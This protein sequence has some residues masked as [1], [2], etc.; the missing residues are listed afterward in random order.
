MRVVKEAEERK[1]EIDAIKKRAEEAEKARNE[2]AEEYKKLK[3]QQ[4]ENSFSELRKTVEG[5][6]NAE[7]ALSRVETQYKKEKDVLIRRAEL[8]ED[9]AGVGIS[10]ETASHDIMLFMN[11]AIEHLDGLVYA[12]DHQNKPSL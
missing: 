3:K 8:A 7:V 10:V 2:A 9:L 6:K 5:N 12:M 4:V 1:E 11:R